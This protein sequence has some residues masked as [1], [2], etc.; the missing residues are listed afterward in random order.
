MIDRLDRLECWAMA[1]DD[2]RPTRALTKNPLGPTGRAVAANVE[3]L[4]VAQNLTFAALS[5]RLE[6]LERPIPPLG[7][8]KIVGETRRVDADDLVGLA[9]ALGVSPS[10]LLMPSGV[11]A[12][13]VVAAADAELK[14]ATL[15]EW[16]IAEWPFPKQGGLME[17]FTRAL[18]A[19]K[20]AEVE[21]RI[22]QRH[23]ESSVA[24][25]ERPIVLNVD[26]G[27]ADGDD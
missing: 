6:R 8:R 7:L 21:R 14:A 4:R 27:G 25:V 5:D 26:E 23:G 3:R 9:V 10:T 1:D 18:P 16:L 24:D 2:Q 15:W 13:E 19:W 17:F 20:L 11:A 22:A 12:D